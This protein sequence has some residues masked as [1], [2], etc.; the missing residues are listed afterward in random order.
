LQQES[1][2]PMLEQGRGKG[3]HVLQP[4]GNPQQLLMQTSSDLQQQERQQRPAWLPSQGALLLQVATVTASVREQDLDVLDAG[5]FLCA[6]L[7]QQLSETITARLAHLPWQGAGPAGPASH[8]AAHS[9]AKDTEHPSISRGMNSCEWS[10]LDGSSLPRIE[11]Q[12]DLCRVNKQQ[13]GLSG[14]ADSTREASVTYD[15]GLGRG[16]EVQVIVS[17]AARSLQLLAN[18]DCPASSLTYLQAVARAGVAIAESVVGYCRDILV[19]GAAGEAAVVAEPSFY[20]SEKAFPS[21][22]GAPA[23]LQPGGKVAGCAKSSAELSRG[24]REQKEWVSRGEQLLS[25]LTE[26]VAECLGANVEM[27]ASIGQLCEMVGGIGN[28]L[29]SLKEHLPKCWQLEARAQCVLNQ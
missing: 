14:D 1:T 7:L 23:D 6:S 26:G 15:V 20:S 19:A 13:C 18:A 2:L 24:L 21:D 8:F 11:E 16:Y 28:V 25:R 9:T 12:R 27:Q 4:Q 10:Y 29:L 22:T 17:S 3:N 5:W